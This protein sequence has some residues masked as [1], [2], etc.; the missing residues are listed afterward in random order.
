MSEL[1]GI[2]NENDLLNRLAEVERAVASLQRQ[3]LRVGAL[4]EM[5]ADLGE[6]WGGDIFA[7]ESGLYPDDPNAT[8]VFLSMNGYTIDGVT[9]RFG[10][11]KNGHIVLGVTTEGQTVT[12]GGSGSLDQGIVLNGVLTILSQL[13]TYG[14]YTRQMRLRMNLPNEANIPG[15]NL[16]PAA[17]WEYQEPAVNELLVNGTFNTNVANWKGLLSKASGYSGKYGEAMGVINPS[18]TNGI[19]YAIAID[20]TTGDIYFGGTFTTINGVSANRAAK[21]TRS[22]GVFSALGTGLNNTCYAI[23]INQT[24][25]EVY[26]G[27]EFTDKGTRCAMWD[28]AW[29]A[30]G[31][32]LDSACYAIA[33]NQTTGAVYFGGEFADKGTR[34]AMWDGA[35]NALGT[36]L[37]GT[38]YAIAINQT[39]GEVYFGGAFTDKGSRCAMWD[40]AWN[41]LGTGLDG[42]CNAIAINQTTGEVYFGGAFTDKGTRCVMWDGAWNELGTGLNN[43]CRAIAVDADG[44]VFFGGLFTQADGISVN[45]IVARATSIYSDKFNLTAGDNSPYAFSGY[46]YNP[47]GKSVQL[48]IKWYDSGDFYISED[49][50]YSGSTALGWTNYTLSPTPPVTAAK[51]Q[52][53]LTID[54]DFMISQVGLDS[55]SFTESSADTYGIMLHPYPL[56]IIDS[57]IERIV[58]ASAF[59]LFSPRTPTISLVATASGNCTNGAHKVKVVFR[60]A[61]G[62]SLASAESNSVTVDNSNKQIRVP[63][64]LGPWGTSARDVYMTKAGGST[65][66]LAKQVEDNTTTTTD[67]SVA[68]ADLTVEEPSTNTSGS[69]A[70]KRHYFTVHGHEVRTSAKLTRPTSHINLA[71]TAAGAANDGDEFYFDFDCVGGTYT[72]VYI[73]WHSTFFGKVDIYIDNA[74]VESGYDLYSSGGAVDIHTGTGIT[75]TGDGVHTLMF[76]VNGKNGSSSDYSF[77]AVMISGYRTGD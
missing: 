63:L 40:G 65:F 20:P 19:I 51:G 13:A 17:S 59:R 22:T 31:T 50:I 43:T 29:N 28:G 57:A 1:S 58:S 35:W 10:A 34:C 76:K 11:V 71:Y 54:G 26:F 41:A 72:L 7:L 21:Y 36:G 4:S 6:F 45:Y 5:S 23:A 39:T 69:R 18:T 16:I 38:C 48:S 15:G 49:V 62:S 68:D 44:N 14:G 75:I 3:N 46:L 73:L 64:E 42:N 66:Y 32:G 55:V 67:V 8:G 37:N 74:P 24:T 52:I 70:M 2:R 33:I 9:Y 12:G 61:Y 30:L 60:D 27:G 25:G 53:Y 56:A 47:L 77:G